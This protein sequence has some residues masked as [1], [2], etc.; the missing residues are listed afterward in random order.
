MIW[1]FE[2]KQEPTKGR[3][4]HLG[5]LFGFSPTYFSQSGYIF[6]KK[7]NNQSTIGIFMDNLYMQGSLKKIGDKKLE[8]EKIKNFPP[9]VPKTSFRFVQKY[10]RK[11]IL[12]IDPLSLFRDHDIV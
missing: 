3:F 10:K 5:S 9:N 2:G 8:I 6:L 11:N 1:E 7:V 12:V 4:V